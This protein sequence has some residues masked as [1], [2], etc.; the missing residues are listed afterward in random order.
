MKRI[1]LL[2]F[3]LILGQAATVFGQSETTASPAADENTAAPAG[4]DPPKYEVQLQYSQESLTRGLGTWRTASLYFERRFNDRQ[5]VWT[6]FRASERNSIRDQEVAAGI[7]RPFG[8]KWAVT[9]EGVFSPTHRFAGKFSV[10]A[11]AERVLKHGF[12][13]HVGTKYTAYNTVKAASVYGIAEKY[14]GNN[15]AAY[16]L[17]LTDLSNAGIAPTH[18][19]QYNR[20]LND[21]RNSIG[22]TVTWGREHENLGPQLGVLRSNTWSVGVSARYWVNRNIGFNADGVLHRQGDLYYRRGMNFGIRFRF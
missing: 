6:T 5:I 8:K 19:I 22:A 3:L 18:R 4:E 16:T 10:M 7:Y 21:A 11:E 13:A 1:V 15:R 20:Y 14:W 9:A 17:Y 2:L 12:V